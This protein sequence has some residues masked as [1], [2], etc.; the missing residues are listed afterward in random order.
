MIGRLLLV[1]TCLTAITAAMCAAAYE[2]DKEVVVSGTTDSGEGSEPTPW[3]YSFLKRDPRSKAGLFD[4]N[5][6]KICFEDDEWI[7]TT[8]ES[9]AYQS[10]KKTDLVFYS[11]KTLEFVG[12]VQIPN[13]LKQFGRLPRSDIFFAVTE[14]YGKY[15]FDDAP[16]VLTV[17]NIRKRKLERIQLAEQDHWLANLPLYVAPHSDGLTLQLTAE[18]FQEFNKAEFSAPDFSALKISYEN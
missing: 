8:D 5:S 6:G 4:S 16:L 11:A 10:N 14:K 12:A 1:Y 18:R 7:V 3:S 2:D 15:N 17:V 13:C 9:N